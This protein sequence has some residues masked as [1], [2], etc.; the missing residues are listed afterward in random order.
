MMNYADEQQ[1]RA[2][3]EARANKLNQYIAPVM[4]MIGIDQYVIAGNSLNGWPINDIDVYFP[5][6]LDNNDIGK[7][8]QNSETTWETP[9]AITIRPKESLKLAIPIDSPPIQLCK[10]WKHPLKVLV[11]SF[12]FAHIQL[13]V[14]FARFKISELYYSSAWVVANALGTTRYLHSEYP[15]SS[16]L[17][18]V[19]Y[20]RRDHP[21]VAT[22]T[23]ILCI[24]I[25]ILK[26][27]LTYDDF[28]EQMNAID[29]QLL[30]EFDGTDLSD[31]ALALWEHFEAFN[32]QERVVS[33]GRE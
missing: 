24:L 5:G 8:E 2:A 16:L 1:L 20:A 21:R 32:G 27:R 18:L 9:N 15:I 23:S 22:R 25:D 28:I 29:V 33:N 11:D 4:R 12:D 6:W 31:I 30:T 10:L 17:R 14:R 13:G 19:K 3:L 26:L 7:L